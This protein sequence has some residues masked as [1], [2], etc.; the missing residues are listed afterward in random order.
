MLVSVVEETHA[1]ATPLAQKVAS[2]TRGSERRRP[3]MITDPFLRRF[4][5]RVPSDIAR[6]FTPNQLD[7]IK[8]VFG[9]AI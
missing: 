7:A 5:E 8:M 3:V 1:P 9:A 2:F 4:F 6:S